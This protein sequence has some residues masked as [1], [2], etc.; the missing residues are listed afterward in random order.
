[1]LEELKSDFC[2]RIVLKIVGT[3]QYANA[4]EVARQAQRFS[5]LGP[6]VQFQ[7]KGKIR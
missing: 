6:T 7:K 2:K 4:S 1:M 3:Q 5:A